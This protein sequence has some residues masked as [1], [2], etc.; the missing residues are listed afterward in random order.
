VS[1]K[2]C[3]PIGLQ[4]QRSIGAPPPRL[5]DELP[6][7]LVIEREGALY[8]EA[9]LVRDIVRDIW[10]QPAIAFRRT[11]EVKHHEWITSRK[12][13]EM[14]PDGCPGHCLIHRELAAEPS[15]RGGWR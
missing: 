10:A 5:W 8:V 2:D 7:E 4:S 11:V 9:A 6:P 14:Y 15:H 1:E 3:G 12:A 13:R